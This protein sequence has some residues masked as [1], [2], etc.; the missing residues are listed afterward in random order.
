M[1]SLSYHMTASKNWPH[2]DLRQGAMLMNTTT[3][4]SLLHPTNKFPVTTQE[5]GQYPSQLVG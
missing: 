1:A 4:L 3:P 5:I 2:L